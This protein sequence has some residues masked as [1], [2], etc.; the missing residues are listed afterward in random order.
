MNVCVDY[1]I[2]KNSRTVNCSKL[3]F[4]ML[5]DS[6]VKNFIEIGHNLTQLKVV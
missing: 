1:K 5:E 4:G 2:Q 6:S 3:K